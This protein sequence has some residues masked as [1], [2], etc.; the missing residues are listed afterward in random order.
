VNGAG[1]AE[2][3]TDG[4]ERSEQDETADVTDQVAHICHLRATADPLHRNQYIYSCLFTITGSK[5][6]KK[7]TS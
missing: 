3:G 2:P 5:K 7:K 4:G 6:K 1:D